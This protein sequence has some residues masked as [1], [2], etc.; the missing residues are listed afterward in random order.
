MPLHVSAALPILEVSAPDVTSWLAERRTELREAV[1][2]HGA[3]LI[4]GLGL[5]SADAVAAA[6]RVLVD[7]LMP[8]YEAFATRSTYEDGVYSSSKWPADQP[9]CMHHELSY[10]LRVPT[11][12]LFAC[13]TA[14]RSGGVTGL[15]DARAVAAALPAEL[16][17]RFERE[18]WLLTRSYNG[19]IG[20]SWTEAFGT[21]DR[22]EV[23]RY[24]RANDIES[25]WL[26]DGTLRTRQR[27]RAL[28]PH[29]ASGERC[30]FNQVAFLNEWTMAPE[31]RE[32]LV[33]VYGREALPFNT[34][35]GSGDPIGEDVIQLLNDVYEAH[36]VREPW[37]RGDLMIVDNVRTA[38]SREA[39]EGTREVL[40][41][42][43]DPMPM[44]DVAR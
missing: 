5:D 24:C 12:L 32:Y 28:I 26:P 34:A 43:G 10:A 1:R 4:R 3:L 29:P 38:H 22:A 9:M 44:V 35:Y 8:H 21:S 13:L 42:M 36:T 16:V 15:A 41:A 25:E 6:F 40:V 7:E 31:I 11:L 14:P 19:E 33:E 20:V 30:W 2:E 18:G 23:E 39:Y 17:E 27:R 37:L